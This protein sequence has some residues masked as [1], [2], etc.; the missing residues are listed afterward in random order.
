[1]S[2]G[3]RQGITFADVHTSWPILA[4]LSTLVAYCIAHSYRKAYL[5]YFY[6][7]GEFAKLHNFDLSDMAPYSLMV[8][9]GLSIFLTCAKDALSRTRLHFSGFIFFLIG[10]QMLLSSWLRGW[11]KP[12][13]Y[14]QLAF[15]A[16][17]F[18]YNFFIPYALRGEGSFL[19]AFEKFHSTDPARNPISG[20]IDI[21]GPKLAP[22]VF[23]SVF[24]FWIATITAADLGYA[25]ALRQKAFPVI[26][27]EKSN[28]A[29]V[30]L[31]DDSYLCADYLMSDH[32]LARQFR[33]VRF[34]TS[35]VLSARDIGPL[36]RR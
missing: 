24:S 13:I 34:D 21:L 10:G 15:F 16:M 25:R 1:M 14:F 19:D 5:A 30:R 7:P 2:N 9:V 11:P 35:V 22:T 8:F 3:E 33:V 17:L 26:V 18:G 23:L 20:M 32:S 12:D 27:G 29:V 6:I 4:A 31:L 28:C 36:E